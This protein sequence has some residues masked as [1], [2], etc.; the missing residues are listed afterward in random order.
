MKKNKY[1]YGTIAATT[2]ITLATVGASTVSADTQYDIF[3]NRVTGEW[4]TVNHATG[5][6][7]KSEPNGTYSSYEEAQASLATPTVETNTDTI[8]SATETTVAEAPKTSA[9]V[10]PALDTQQ[11]V[12]DA[13]AQNA[14]NAQAD[15]D[16]ADQAVV[17]AQADVNTA[18]QAV[19][20]AEANAVNATPE[21]IA[22]NQA[23][24]AANLADQTAN[25]TET[26]QVNA[27]IASQTQT[28][29]DAQT[30]VDTAQAEKDAADANVAAKEADVKAAQDAISGTGL[31]EAQANLD[32]AKADV[33][34]AESNVNTA[35]K[36]V[37]TATKAVDTAKKADAERDAK[38]KDAETDVKTKSDAVTTAS[39]RVIAAQG[40]V[41][42]TTDTLTKANDA[43]K[44]AQDAL[45]NVDTENININL[46]PELKEIYQA[47]LNRDASVFN[48]YDFYT[49]NQIEALAQAVTGSQNVKTAKERLS[50]LTSDPLILENNKAEV[51]YLTS[52]IENDSQFGE[53]DFTLN[54]SEDT[55]PVDVNNLTEEQKIEINKF[56]AKV[57]TKIRQTLGVTAPEVLATSY[58]IKA[59]NEQAEKYLRRGRTIHEWL[60][61][62]V[63]NQSNAHIGH[64][65]GLD[66]LSTTGAGYSPKTMSELKKHV[67]NTL[68]GFTFEDKNSNWGHALNL[69]R[70][71]TKH[72]VAF[73]TIKNH[74][75]VIHFMQ[76]SGAT[77]VYDGNNPEPTVSYDRYEAFPDEIKQATIYEDSNNDPAT[78]QAA[79]AKA[80]ADQSAAQAA[81]DTA[82]ANLVKASS[83]Y[84]KA[85]ELKTQAEKTLA[86]AT[87]TP[88]QTQVA[89]NNLRLATIALQN[90]E[91]RK[92]DAQKAVDN[93]S[94]DLADKKAALDTAKADL[95]QAQATATAKAEALETAKAELAKQQGTLDSLNKDKDALLAEKDR[96]VEEAKALATELKGY[97]EAPAILANAQATLTEKQAALTEA[98]AKAKV[99]HEKLEGLNT[100]LAE[101]KAKLAELQAEYNK[102]KDLEDKA[103]D[104]V[105]ATL[106]DGTIVAVPKDAPTAAEKPAID[107]D[108]VKDAITKSQD[109]TVVDGEVVVTNPQAGV[110][111]TQTA[112]GEKV[113]YSRVER[114]K[115][116]PNT[117]EQ[118]SLLALAGLTV[119]SSLGL[120][121]ARR[122]KQG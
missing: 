38:I 75:H 10:K 104:N 14:T 8:V 113:T 76:D 118:T 3:L 35:T 103:K 101:E 72:G 94:A 86:D 12:V 64:P 110:T 23:D 77:L 34:T 108:A 63:E 30:A 56:V 19:S 61:G 1:I 55:T 59:A 115:T 25:A 24:Q 42:S 83:D 51:D 114:A 99:A 45:D 117:G 73:A 48:K 53:S 58:T 69:L 9:D 57:I 29:A 60:T 67:F 105:I 88:L 32:Q 85:L 89:E 41:A 54:I 13:T 66:N 36:A 46:S 70:Y 109:V 95:A 50:V 44:K 74:L 111:V 107:V 52:I 4:Q 122:R 84:A 40:K 93:F 21:N 80:Q 22:A 27:E 81:S 91:A 18:T 97:L 6:I 112:T 116:L 39:N 33:K 62:S 102:L 31:A 121:S 100:K 15:A 96:L 78:L 90:A 119:L 71:G 26:D 79:L 87:A 68:I 43:A 5:E 37:D 65:Y 49:T 92:A 120:V 7:V 2:A 47:F 11:A 20:D 17:T 98:Q 82:Q 106:P 16:A 28:V